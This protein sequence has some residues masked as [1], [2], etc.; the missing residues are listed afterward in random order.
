MVQVC[1]KIAQSFCNRSVLL[2]I[3]LNRLQRCGAYDPRFLGHLY[4]IVSKERVSFE[5]HLHMSP[6]HRIE[7]IACPHRNRYEVDTTLAAYLPGLYFGSLSFLSFCLMITSCTVSAMD[8][9]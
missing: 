4:L 1:S 2:R 9:I 7:V 3:S 8:F 5:F 6:H